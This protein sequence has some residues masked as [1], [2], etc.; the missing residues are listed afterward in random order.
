MLCAF[1]GFTVPTDGKK[2]SQDER[3]ISLRSLRGEKMGSAD[4]YL[5]LEQLKSE[6]ITLNDKKIQEIDSAIQSSCN[7][8]AALVAYGWSGDAKEA[9]MKRFSEYK[10]DMR[11]FQ[12][13]MKEF[14]RQLKTIHSNGKKLVSKGNRIA[15]KL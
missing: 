4:T 10:R 11:N 5:D 1:Q 3:F 6:A 8:M 15:S 2:T 14:N 12:G 9:F 13:Y 7:A